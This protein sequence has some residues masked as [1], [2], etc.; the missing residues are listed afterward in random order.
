MEQTG[1][2][3]P[4]FC[5]TGVMSEK[6]V[7]KS[8]MSCGGVGDGWVVCGLLVVCVDSKNDKKYKRKLLAFQTIL[9][10]FMLKQQNSAE[11][12]IDVSNI[13]CQSPAPDCHTPLSLLIVQQHP[14]AAS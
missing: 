2:S 4:S 10:M 7:W 6:T 1:G 8:I 9:P 12:P 11:T 13:H 5:G 14:Y 3:L